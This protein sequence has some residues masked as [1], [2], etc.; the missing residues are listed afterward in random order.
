MCL[1]FL[2]FSGNCRKGSKMNKDIVCSYLKANCKGKYNSISS[3]S[4]EK[5]LH[6]SGNEL[7]KQVN[8]LRREAVPIASSS[9]GYFYA[10]TAGEIYST[11]RSLKKMRSGLDEAIAG[12]ERALDDFR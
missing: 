11:I 7:R 5:T 2:P 10:E 12:L 1:Y 9:A 4:L 8:G 6:M 3:S